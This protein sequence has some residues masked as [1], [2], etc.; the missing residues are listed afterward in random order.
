LATH[1]QAPDVES[2]VRTV[3]DDEVATFRENGWVKLD[4][5]LDTGLVA[6]VLERLQARMGGDGMGG[7]IRQQT[8]GAHRRPEFLASMWRN[9]EDPSADD[10]FLHAFSHAPALGRVASRLLGDRPVRFFSDEVFAKPGAK[11]GSSPTAWH[12][13]SPYIPMDR[14]GILSI[15]IPLVE[16]PPEMGSLRFYSGSHRLGNLGRTFTGP[17]KDVFT[18]NPGLADEIEPAPALHLHPGDATVHD[19]RT[20]HGAAENRTDRTRW[21]YACA[22]FPANALYTGAPQRICDGLG[23]E[24]NQPFDHPRFTE[25]AT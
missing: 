7:E 15:W 1:Q 11:D 6:R 2:G 25:I 20:I 21:A 18:E 10:E 9:Y 16:M 5:L 24:V 8:S 13:D 4:G 23:L 12:Q 19:W 22:Y 14:V 3:T 17:G